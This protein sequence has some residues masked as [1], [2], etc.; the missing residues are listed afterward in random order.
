MPPQAVGAAV[1]ACNAVG[2]VNACNAV[3]AD[4]CQCDCFAF[5]AVVQKYVKVFV[6]GLFARV[7]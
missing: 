5:F 1:E 6:D 4:V 3:C 2:A 7:F